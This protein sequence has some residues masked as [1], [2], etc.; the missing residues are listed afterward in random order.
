MSTK[1]LLLNIN[2]E[3]VASAK[4]LGDAEGVVL[5]QFIQIPKVDLL[6]RRKPRRNNGTKCVPDYA[7]A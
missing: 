2:D 3:W 7:T 4:L 5:L 1:S 6:F